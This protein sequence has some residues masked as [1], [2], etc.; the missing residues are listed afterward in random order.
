MAR[1][2]LRKCDLMLVDE[3]TS[4][5]DVVTTCEV[6]DH[7]LDLDCT[8]IMITHDIFGEYMKHFDRICYLEQGRVKENGTFDGLM[9]EN[10]GFFSPLRV[11]AERLMG[12]GGEWVM[13]HLGDKGRGGWM[14]AL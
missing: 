9:K 5:L 6:M 1:A 7:L 10:G 14:W 12:A 8:V 13:V 3:S 2:I 4:S 11:L